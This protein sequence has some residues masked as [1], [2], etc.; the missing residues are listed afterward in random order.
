MGSVYFTHSIC[1]HGSYVS[2]LTPD[3]TCSLLAGG[4]QGY[5]DGCGSLA[6]FRNPRGIAVAPDG[7]LVVCDMLNHVV[8]GVSTKDGTVTTLAGSNTS[9]HRDSIDP[10]SACFSHPEGVAVDSE[11]NIFVADYGSHYIRKICRH[12]GGV[13]TVAG[14]GAGH[15]DGPAG[16]AM[17]NCPKDCAVDSE[18]SIFV[19]DTGNGCVRKIS[20]SSGEGY[21]VSTFAGKGSEGQLRA[22]GPCWISDASIGESKRSSHLGE[23]KQHALC[24]SLSP[25]SVTWTRVARAPFLPLT[26]CMDGDLPSL[27]LAYGC[28]LDHIWAHVRMKQQRR[29]CVCVCVCRR[30]AGRSL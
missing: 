4:D 26:C 30:R 7:S 22:R 8:R 11:G 5:R 12:S 19:T 20:W 3:G 27:A 14:C 6:R 24:P 13:T 9:G 25:S 1:G 28:S 2:K 23:H 16:L 18:G 29:V 17:F 15:L 10:L 21:V